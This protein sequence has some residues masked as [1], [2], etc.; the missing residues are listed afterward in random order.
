MELLRLFLCLSTAIFIGWNI[1]YLIS[2][3]SGKLSLPE[4]A[5]ISYGFGLGFIS[6]EMFCFHFFSIKF[7]ILTI[8]V[9]WL[10][11]LIINFVIA[12]E[13]SDRSNPEGCEDAV[14]SNLKR[15]CLPAG[16]AGF[17]PSGLAMTVRQQTPFALFL[18][19]GIALEILYAFFRALIK[20]VEAYDA[21]ATYAIRSKIFYIGR[22][23]PQDF[24][25][26]LSILLPHPDYPLNIPLS[27]T[28]VYLF[29]GSQNDQLVKI[30]FPLYF[31]AIL[32]ILYFGV[33]RFGSRTLALVFTFILATI[34]QFNNFATN[35]YHDIPL[36]YYCFA[37]TV[38]LL[39][40]FEKKEFPGYLYISAAMTAIAGW[41]KNE[42]FVYCAANIL[43]LLIFLSVNRRSIN[44]RD[45]LNALL[46]IVIILSI[47]APWLWVKFSANLVNSD[48]GSTT[49][50]Q[51]NL[52]KQSHK[53]WP[54]CYEFQRQ[55]FG[56][57]KWNMIWIVIISAGVVY[58][59]KI[60]AG[61]QKH[62]T[63]SLIL[64]VSGYIFAYLIGKDDI[65]HMVGTTWSRMLI[66][67]LPLAVYWLACLL[68][69]EIKI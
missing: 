25:Y 22:S 69:G 63:I 27:E 20:P 4:R 40:W 39:Y 33:R 2:F 31:I 46:Y 48:V 36:A 30:I 60:F 37:G 28:F 50:D 67:F 16:Q 62:I 56:P 21:I 3:R 7:S 9:P 10:L 5:F 64:I 53:I 65:Q 24:F 13:R 54:I 26:N 61:N 12:R 51:L 6:I 1:L 8:I 34:P 44:K 29:L 49:I 19:A 23:I 47:L 58:H 45:V 68:K 38:F 52:I 18:I 42:G 43:L 35:A 15:D 11:L 55:V 17:A 57:K 32:G 41:T 59:K 66:H 14:R